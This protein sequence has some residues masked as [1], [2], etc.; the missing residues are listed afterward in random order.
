[1]LT[2][3]CRRRRETA[4]RHISRV[5]NSL[6]PNGNYQKRELNI[7]SFLNKYGPSFLKKIEEELKVDLFAHQLIRV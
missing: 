4:L 7:I 6:Y 3:V 2:G 1:L 5:G